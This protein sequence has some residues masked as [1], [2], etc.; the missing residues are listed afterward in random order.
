MA[1]PAT[2]QASAFIW[3]AGFAVAIAAHL[4]FHPQ[5]SVF[6][7]AL[8][9][10][11]SQP[12][13]LLA[14]IICHFAALHDFEISKPGVSMMVWPDFLIVCMA[15]GAMQ[16]GWMLLDVARW[17]EFP[18][19]TIGSPWLHFLWQGCAAA[20]TQTGLCL[21]YLNQNPKWVTARW[22]NV[23]PLTFILTLFNASAHLIRGEF[24][25]CILLEA[26][27]ITAPLPYCIAVSREGFISI[28]SH[29]LLLWRRLWFSWIG[30]AM[31]AV[32]MLALLSHATQMLALEPGLPSWIVAS[33]FSAVIH[34]W[35][36]TA[37]VLLMRNAG[38]LIRPT[39]QQ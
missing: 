12:L 20:M 27:L 35:L 17:H 4:W 7:E 5:R 38:Y 30:F 28:G 25:W 31:T 22:R 24:Q 36:F 34:L 14:I 13:L 15:D 39:F 21:L 29:M 16:F 8:R 37:G 11:R 2:N 6:I 19:I 9:R 18:T 32:L 33:I 3:L 23:I 10:L 1:S 26:L